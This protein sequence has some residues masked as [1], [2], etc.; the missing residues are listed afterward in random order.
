M[1]W[2][3]LA[4]RVRGFVSSKSERDRDLQAEIRSHIEIETDENI[5]SGMNAGEARRTALLKFG[6]AQLAHERSRRMWSLPSWD[7]FLSDLKFGWRVLW[8]EPAFAAV[9][10]LTLALGIGATTAIFSVAYAVLVRPLPYPEAQQLVL[11]HQYNKANDTGNWR[12]T[13]FDYLDWR[14]RAHSFSGVAA[15]TGTG[16][17]LRNNDSAEM[18]LGQRVSYNFFSVV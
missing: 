17:V 13:A 7:S 6:G 4:A 12:T 2:R 1:S 8:K 15:Y 5:D 16:L 11:V 9:A 18:V 14:E 3:T 10:I